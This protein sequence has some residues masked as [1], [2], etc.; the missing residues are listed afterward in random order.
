MER[1]QAK[2]MAGSIIDDM[3][4]ALVSLSDRIWANPETKHE[5]FQ[6]CEWLSRFLREHSLETETQVAGLKTSFVSHR[7]G[8][9]GKPH[10]GYLAEY[11]A[12]PGIGHACGHNIIGVASAAAGVALARVLDQ[13][14]SNAAVTVFGCPGE[15]GGGGKVY[16]ARAGLFDGV[17]AAM[18][19]HPA[20]SNKAGTTSNASGRVHCR[21]R[22]KSA[23]GAGN[24]Q[25]G[26]NALDGVIQTFNMVNGLRQMVPEDVRLMGIITNGGQVVNA[27]PDLAECQFSIRAARLDTH[28]QV[29]DRLRK[30]AEAAAMATGTTL[31][32]EEPEHF[33]H[34]P[35][36]PNSVLNK[37]F[38]LNMEALGAKMSSAQHGGR[39]STDFGNVSW[40]AP[41][42]H[43]YVAVVPGGVAGHSVEMREACGSAPGHAGLVLAAKAL[44]MSGI[45][46]VWD[47]EIVS[48]AWKEFRALAE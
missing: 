46:L 23:H 2:R 32:M 29:M 14:G 5:E 36:R 6:A 16:M 27:I 34:Y 25:K 44:A 45:D 20:D 26:I 40:V 21:F 41:G 13:L 43:G 24:P 12:L 47:P 10:V 9:R 28:R 38:T 3:T 19:V 22:G 39:G 18:M 1:E 17:D 7:K 42:M 31:E 48:N 11:D 4:D 35:V 15:E 8:G 37:V 33:P 30:C